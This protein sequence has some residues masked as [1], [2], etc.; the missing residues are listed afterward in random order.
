MIIDE[1]EGGVLVI[2]CDFCNKEVFA[3]QLSFLFR[4]PPSFYIPFTVKC[5]ECNVSNN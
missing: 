5:E 3:L 4:P 2:K 1:L